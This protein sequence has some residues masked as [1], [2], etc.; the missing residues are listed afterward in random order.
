MASCVGTRIDT[1][2]DTHENIEVRGSHSGLGFNPSVLYAIADRLAQPEDDWRPFVPPLFLRR[3][4]PPPSAG[5][6]WRR[7]VGA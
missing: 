1:V 7:S 5:N 6:R 4:Y 2:D 3:A